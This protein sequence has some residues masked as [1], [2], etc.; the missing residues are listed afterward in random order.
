MERLAQADPN[1]AGWQRDLS[2]SYDSIGDVQVT[3]GNLP[4]ALKSFRASLAIRERLAQADPNT[5]AGRR[6]WRQA[7]ASLGRRSP[8]WANGLTRSRSFTGDGRLPGRW[9]SGPGTPYGND[10]SRS[11]TPK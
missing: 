7:A 9:R 4:E 10:M 2:V 5:R 8:K 6:T 3:Q 11:S 1:N